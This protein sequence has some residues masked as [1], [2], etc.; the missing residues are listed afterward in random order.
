[1]L[2]NNMDKNICIARLLQMGIKYDF[3]LSVIIK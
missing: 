3:N 2:K 1:M